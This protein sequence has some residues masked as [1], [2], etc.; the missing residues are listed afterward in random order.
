[1]AEPAAFVFVVLTFVVSLQFT[2]SPAQS[3]STGVSH[4][5]ST[6]HQ[7]STH[8]VTKPVAAK[9]EPAAAPPAST[10]APPVRTPP[11]TSGSTKVEPVVKPAPTAKVSGLTPTSPAA[12]SG[13]SQVTTGYTSLNWSGYLAT[14]AAFTS[15]SG[16]W[17][18]TNAAGNGAST[19]ADSTWI[20]I[21]GVTSGDLIQV[22]TQN[23]ISAS[24]NRTTSAFYEMLPAASIN[25]TSMT[26]TAGDSMSASVSEIGSSVWSI[27]IT[28]NTTGGSFTKTV[29]YGSSLSSAEW[30]EEDPSYAGGS[31]VPF[32]SFNEAVFTSASAVA[33]G[34]T[35]NLNSST[36]QPVIMVNNSGT[37][38]AVPSTISGGNSFTVTP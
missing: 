23:I 2:G 18:A 17:T 21:G 29:S 37:Y 7:A 11:A 14:N 31:L 1:M 26:V 3:H 27:S 15:V 9:P 24:G 32:D 5:K 10:A 20:G 36:A 34:A 35:V 33:N 16:S 38:I 28:D 4:K 19:S 8:K 25:I 6:T 30:I 13:S 22:G 12:P